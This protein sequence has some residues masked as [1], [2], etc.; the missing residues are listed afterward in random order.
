MVLRCRQLADCRRGPRR[1]EWVQADRQVAGGG[2]VDIVAAAERLPCQCAGFMGDTGVAGVDPDFP[3][4]GG[5]GL[6]AAILIAWVISFVSS[7]CRGLI[8]RVRV[9]PGIFWWAGSAW[10]SAASAATRGAVTRLCIALVI[11][12][13]PAPG[14]DGLGETSDALGPC[15]TNSRNTNEQYV[16]DWTAQCMMRRFWGAHSS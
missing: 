12:T 6:K 5:G 7:R 4:D 8:G 15:V 11:R 9:L 3:G 14:L 16:I 2:G 13:P 10:S 1:W